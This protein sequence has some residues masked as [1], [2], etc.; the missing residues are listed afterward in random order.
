MTAEPYGPTHRA[1]SKELNSNVIRR[2][3]EELR[4]DRKEFSELL[5]VNIDT[6]R[7]WE[8]NGKSRPRGRAA[9]K[10]VVIAER[11]DYPMTIEEIFQK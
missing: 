9:L 10:I 4:L 1:D 11:N 8:T 5:E 2:F 7:V 3:R 6:L